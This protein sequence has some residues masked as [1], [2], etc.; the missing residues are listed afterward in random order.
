MID[1]C[2]KTC[3]VQR[4]TRSVADGHYIIRGETKYVIITIK[5]VKRK[6][7]KTLPYLK[8]ETKYIIVIVKKKKKKK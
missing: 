4:H 3:Y 5:K 8:G 1:L 2:K 7:K 6:E